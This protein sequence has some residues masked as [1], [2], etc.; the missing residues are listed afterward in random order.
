MIVAYVSDSR[1]MG[2]F[3]FA[4]TAWWMPWLQRRPGIIRPVN[5]STIT[6]SRFR[7]T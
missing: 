1:W 6:I 5:S 7:T 2:T 4:S 3:S